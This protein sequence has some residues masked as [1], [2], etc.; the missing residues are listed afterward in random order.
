[1]SA[2]EKNIMQ[3]YYDSS[4]WLWGSNYKEK[5]HRYYCH[6]ENNT[7]RKINNQ[8]VSKNILL[9]CTVI[10]NSAMPIVST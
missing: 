10:Q 2:T 3:S 1:M 4:Y 7:Q 9:K 6:Y 5:N 8:W